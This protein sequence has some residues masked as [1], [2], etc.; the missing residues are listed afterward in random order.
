MTVW[1]W[2]QVGGT[3]FEE[4]LIVPAASGQGRRM[5]DAVILIDG[6][7]RRMPIGSTASLDDRDVVLV[8][9]KFARL[10]MSL[11]GQTLFS[12]DLVKRVS[13]P[14]SVRS[15]ALCKASDAVLQ[16]LLERHD[17]CQVVIYQGADLGPRGLASPRESNRPQARW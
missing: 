11:M 1:Y 15:V 6:E 14:R 13:R 16:P 10:G 3:L 2:E 4:F 12:R 9:T 5:L 7:R 8:Q 17:G